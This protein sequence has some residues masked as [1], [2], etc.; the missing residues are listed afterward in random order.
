MHVHGWGIVDAKM[1]GVFA[2]VYDRAWGNR[3]KKSKPVRVN[4]G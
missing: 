2:N 3:G 4:L 1:I